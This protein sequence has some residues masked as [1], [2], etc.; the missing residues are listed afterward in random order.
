MLEWTE[1]DMVRE[2]SE[3]IEDRVK[4]DPDSVC[5]LCDR[6]G[7]FGAGITY[8]QTDDGYLYYQEPVEI[9]DD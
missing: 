9:V 8:R 1:E 2:L 3:E 4:T 5:D 6:L 7:V